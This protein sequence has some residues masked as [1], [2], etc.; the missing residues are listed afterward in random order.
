MS[1]KCGGFYFEKKKAVLG[2][3]I[4]LR[5]PLVKHFSVLTL[6]ENM[7]WFPTIKVLFVF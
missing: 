7:V 5:S 1:S 4:N 2:K 6:V 3:K